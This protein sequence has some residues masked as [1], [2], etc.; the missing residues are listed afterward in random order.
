MVPA[1]GSLDFSLFRAFPIGGTQAARVPARGGQHLQPY[2]VRQPEGQHHLRHVRTDHGHRGPAIRSARSSWAS[3]S[4]SDRRSVSA[5]TAAFGRR[6]HGAAP[7]SCVFP[8]QPRRLS[9]HAMPS[10]ALAL[11]ASA[12]RCCAVRSPSPRARQRIRRRR[13]TRIE[14]AHATPQRTRP[15]LEAVGA[16]GRMLHAWEQWDAA[17]EAYARAAGAGAARLR[18]ARTSTPSCCSVSR[19]QRKPRRGSEAALASGRRTTCRRASSWPRRCSK[20]GTSMR[21]SSCSR[22]C[23]AS[24]QPSRRPSSVSDGSPRPRAGTSAAVAHLERAVTLFPEWGAAYYALALSYRA[25]GRRDDARARARAARAV[26]RALAGGRR[27]GARH[28]HVA[29]RDD[30]RARCCSAG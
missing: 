22:R 23:A 24:R 2:G 16:L 3:G 13:V 5:L 4:R 29:L 28:G 12:S 7:S 6:R 9:A 30:A 17:H 19:G 11:A 10:I 18:L 8:A 20:P 21:A 26:R 14:R 25:L 15:T 27:S 1:A